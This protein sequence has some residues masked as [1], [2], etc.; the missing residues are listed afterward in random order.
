M[1]EPENKSYGQILK[2]SALIGGSSA[3]TMAFGIIRT[4]A[5]A[6]LLGAAG[7]GVLGLY[8]AIS[9]LVRNLAGLGINSSGVRQ[10]AEAVGSGDEEKIAC[11]VTTLRRV[12]LISGILGALIL[13]GTAG[14]ISQFTF[15]DRTHAVAI[16]LLALV[17]FFGDISLAQGALVQGM[18]RIGDLAK[19]NILG[20]LYGTVFGIV[21][22]Y[23]WRQN[24]LAPSLVCVAGM[25]IVT[26]W[27]YARKIKVRAVR[28]PWSRVFG[29]ASALVKLGLI[30]MA[31]GLATLGSAY[32][33]RK[34]V[35]DGLGEKAAG[36]YQ[37][38][39]GL[40]GLYIGF[41]LQAMTADFYPRLTGVA[42]NNEETNRLVNEQTEIGLL[43][44]GPGIL[45]TLTLAPLAILIFYTSDFA[46]AVEVLRWFCLGML[47][48]VVNWPMGYI[49]LAR[50]E[51]KLFFWTEVLTNVLYVALVWAGIGMLGLRGVGVGFFG[52]YVVNSVVVYFI[53]R[54]LTG[55]RLSAANKQIA[56]LF[57]PLVAVV[58]VLWYFL[59]PLVA[60]GVGAA[61]SAIASAF[62]ARVLCKLIPPDRLPRP[63]QKMFR[64]LK[65]LPNES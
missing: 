46:P 31:S 7:V 27:W 4:K 56:F 14:L 18:R 32:F 2:S 13:V 48:K 15:H 33:V 55:F 64:I 61:V 42:H 6:L 41:I 52:L 43:M 47:L 25:S 3:F 20:A 49:I 35:L 26:S 24:G 45:G 59:P 58:F 5:M 36:Y 9:D 51:R 37:A 22:V 17:A 53:V 28:I 23:F 21:I 1:A 39:W 16:A 63:A 34:I 11:T 19:M 57:V 54:R 12:A 40:S 29:E 8:V 65:L 62:S 60:I 44:A 50:G 10:I 38:A 30:F